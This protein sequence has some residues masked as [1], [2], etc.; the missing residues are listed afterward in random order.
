MVQAVDEINQGKDGYSEVDLTGQLAS[1]KQTQQ[2]PW[3]ITRLCLRDLTFSRFD[4]YRRVT[5]RQT[6]D[7]G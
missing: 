3:A 1:E 6:H 7:D 5:D 2:S 4:T